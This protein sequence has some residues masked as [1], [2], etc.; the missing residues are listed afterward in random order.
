MFGILGGG[1]GLYGHLPAIAH[2]FDDAIVL[3]QRFQSTFL[4]R[5]ELQQFASRVAWAK[6]EHDT[7]ARS[8]TATLALTPVGQEQWL[9]A[10]TGLSNVRQLILEK[11][12]ATSSSIA[13]TLL[14]RLIDAKK[15]FRVNYT[16]LYTPWFTWLASRITKARA[17]EHLSLRWTFHAHHY[18]HALPNWKRVPDQGGG[19]LRFYGIHLVAALAAL[20]PCEVLRSTTFG[21]TFEDAASWTAELLV[22]GVRLDLVVDSACS[23]TSFAIES[24]TRASEAAEEGLRLLDPFAEFQ[25]KDG[26]DPRVLVLQGLY[27]SLAARSEDAAHVNLCLTVQQLWQAIEAKTSHHIRA[28]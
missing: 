4:A 9:A 24:V 16:F 26:E 6:D 23:E 11:P 1:F 14:G 21:P 20:G 10:C 19:A 27:K 18:R 22:S 3:P 15:P 25:A 8:H 7:L 13:S 28:L 5:R 2:A 17:P 12:L